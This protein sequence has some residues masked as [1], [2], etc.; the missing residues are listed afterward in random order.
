MWAA[1][2]SIPVVL[3][4]PVTVWSFAIEIVPVAVAEVVTGGV[5]SDPVKVTLTSLANADAANRAN[6][7][8]ARRV[9]A[10]RDFI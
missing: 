5:S 9:S 10:G 3:I 7:V 4:D 1:T 2:P 6:V 8:V